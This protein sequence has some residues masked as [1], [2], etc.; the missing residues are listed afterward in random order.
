MMD[1]FLALSSPNVWNLV[2]SFKHRPK[3]RGYIYNILVL[4]VNNGYCYIQD[5]CFP[6]Q[7]TKEKLFL[8]KMFMRGDGSGYDLVKW[9]EPRGDLQTTLIMF[10][11]VKHVEGWTTLACHVYDSFYCWS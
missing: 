9:M 8:F 7:Q 6:R 10:D 11:R 2:I 3:N 4:K 1:K 5:N